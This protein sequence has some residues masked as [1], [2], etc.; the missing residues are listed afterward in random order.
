MP[1]VEPLTIEQMKNVVERRGGDIPRVPFFWHKTYNGGT[2]ERHGEKLTE[3]NES[4]VDDVVGVMWSPPGDFEAPEGFP[5]DYKWAIEDEPPNPEERGITSR[6]VISS[7]DLID[8]FIEAMPDPAPFHE[9]VYPACAIEANPDR[10]R[11]GWDMFTLF[12]RAWFLF[13]MADIMCEMALN[14][15]RMKRLCRAFTNYHKKAMDNLAALGTHAYFATDDLGS[16]D[17]LLFSR[18]QFRDIYLP[19]YEEMIDH[20]HGL[21]MTFWLHSC[22]AMT[23]LLDDFISVGLDA[24]HPIQP[25]AMDQA[26]VAKKYAGKITFIAGMDVQYLL[27]GCTVDEVIAGTKELVDTFDRAEGGLILA[28]ANAIMPE[29]PFDNIA[30]WFN[31]A[32]A[33]GAEHRKQFQ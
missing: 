31:T 3:L 21:G 26:A 11:V 30:A 32:Q 28:S 12:E 23:E 24:L 10:Y 14:P 18:K 20:C 27:P 6:R 1:S 5:P 15:E 4:I 8:D 29:T 19:F 9:G 22:G 33:Y 16:Q 7:T 17:R 2:I 13:G 25:H